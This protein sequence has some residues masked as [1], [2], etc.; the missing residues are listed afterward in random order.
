[1]EKDIFVVIKQIQV[2]KSDTVI[3]SDIDVLAVFDIRKCA[4][5]AIDDDVLKISF[6]DKIKS[7]NPTYDDNGCLD[8]YIVSCDYNRENYKTIYTYMV[9]QCKYNLE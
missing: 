4:E 2:L 8:S 3:E 1:M 7:K 6:F 9:R 5:L